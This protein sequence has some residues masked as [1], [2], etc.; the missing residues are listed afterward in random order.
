MSIRLGPGFKIDK[1]GKV[2]RDHAASDAKLSVSQRLQKR[3][4]KK[5]RVVKK[6]VK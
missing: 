4:S 3:K 1:Q 2:V 6:G 5:V